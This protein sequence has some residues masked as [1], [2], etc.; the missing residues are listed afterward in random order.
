VLHKTSQGERQEKDDDGSLPP[1]P[2]P[3]LINE[4]KVCKNGGADDHR[5]TIA[6]LHVT[7]MWFKLTVKVV[8][9]KVTNR[10]VWKMFGS[11]QASDRWYNKASVDAD[12]DDSFDFVFIRRLFQHHGRRLCKQT[13]DMMPEHSYSCFR[14]HYANFVYNIEFEH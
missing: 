8:V 7:P 2:S 11:I 14:R 5:S 13:L 9:I 10:Y 3:R 12:L 6:F 4:R 1:P